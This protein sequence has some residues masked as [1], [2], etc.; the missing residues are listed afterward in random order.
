MLHTPKEIAAASQ[1]SCGPQT[2]MKMQPKRPGVNMSVT[3]LDE[4]KFTLLER[5]DILFE[6]E[7]R[8]LLFPS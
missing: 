5:K 4:R 8:L 6:T 2:E 1:Q 7:S 3:V